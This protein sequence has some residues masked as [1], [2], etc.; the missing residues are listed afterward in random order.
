MP[1]KRK[2][3]KAERENNAEEASRLR[4]RIQLRKLRWGK[5]KVY[6][7]SALRLAAGI[8]GIELPFLNNLKFNSMKNM[9]NFKGISGFAGELIQRLFADKPKFFIWGQRITAV[10]GVILVVLKTISDPATGFDLYSEVCI[11]AF[12]FVPET[13]INY[14]IAGCA[15]IIAA[16]QL[17]TPSLNDKQATADGPRS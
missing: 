16:F 14:A 15:G 9:N 6:L 11:R 13:I 1:L 12:C 3:K 17:P 7:G 10:V 5:A 4:S 2:L 8:F